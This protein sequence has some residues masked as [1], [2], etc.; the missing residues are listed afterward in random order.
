MPS[1]QLVFLN[2]NLLRTLPAD[3]FSGTNLARL[4]LRNNYF[5]SL[6]V[7]GVLEHLTSLVQIDLH[8]NPWECSCDIIPLKQWVEKLSSVIVVGDVICKTPEFASGKDLRSL[9][10]EVLC[11]ELKFSGPSPALP[12]D[13]LNGG[14]TN[15]GEASH[16]GAVPLSVLI[17]S[18]L[19]LFISAVF[20]AAG[21][22]AFVLR[23]RKKLP[24]RKRSEVDLT[25]IQ[26][27]C[28]IF[29]DPPRPSSAGN[30]ATPEKATPTLH[31]HSSHS[32]A[33]AHGHVYDYIPHPVTQM[34]N[35]PIYKPREG[36]IPEEGRQFTEKKESGSS[37]NNYRTLLEKER[38]WTLA[39]S[40]SQLNTIVTV[41]HSTA[42]M[43]GFHENGGL[44]PTV[45]DSQRP[46]PTVGFVDCLYGTVPKLKDMHVAHAHPPGM[47]Y[48]DLQQDARLKETLLF[49]AGKG[50]FPDPSQS[51]YL[52]LRAKLQTKPDYLEVLEKSYR[53]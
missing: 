30:I 45:I 7:R 19:I 16:R 8:Q 22:F 44:C 17:L 40:N 25:G 6:P 18:L 4:N 48:P 42:D 31:T 41:N 5:L 12:G 13:D 24:F 34:C 9:E 2:D 1:L 20:V 47:Q 46:T 3:V 50:C 32:H 23:R 36:E 21:L 15:M 53:F 38:E 10:V 52:E 35:N 26:M 28:R 51:D 11:P 37:S 29:E 33:H 14:G 39:V 49:T 27:Q 43:A